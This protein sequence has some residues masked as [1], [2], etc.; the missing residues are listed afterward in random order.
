MIDEATRTAILKLNEQGHGSRVIAKAV[1]AARSTVRQVINSG[2]RE[3]PPLVRPELAEPY[4][5]QILDLHAQY[6]GHLGRVHEALV[7]A[8][9]KLSYQALT[10]F[11]RRHGIGRE[12]PLPAGRYHFDP[13]SCRTTLRIA[14]RFFFVP[15]TGPRAWGACRC[16]MRSGDVVPLLLQEPLYTC[17]MGALVRRVS[18]VLRPSVLVRRLAWVGVAEAA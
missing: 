13:A 3:V 1:G 10:A 18:F 12:P 2:S 8:G 9:A 11:V 16:L 14:R 7:G 6:E 4:R 17:T 5:Q 15:A